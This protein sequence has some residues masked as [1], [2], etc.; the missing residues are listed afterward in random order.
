[1]TLKKLAGALMA[2]GLG[3]AAFGAHAQ[4]SGD[5]VKIGDDFHP[6]SSSFT[7]ALFYRLALKADGGAVNVFNSMLVKGSAWEDSTNDTPGFGIGYND[8]AQQLSGFIRDDVSTHTWVAVHAK[9]SSSLTIRDATFHHAALVV[10]RDSSSPR[11]SFY[12]DGKITDFVAV[13]AGY[14]PI[15]SPEIAQLGSEGTVNNPAIQLHG[16]LDEVMI[17]TRALGAAEIADL[18]ARTHD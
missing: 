1:M 14:G 5:K 12:V 4:V 11:V 10:D 16:A 8:G 2:V 15:D 18:A 17:F 3:A 13:P 6:G 7:V 9:A